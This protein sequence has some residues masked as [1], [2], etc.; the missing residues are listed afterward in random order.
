MIF[1]TDDGAEP[2]RQSRLPIDEAKK[3]HNKINRIEAERR[4][5]DMLECSGFFPRWSASMNIRTISGGMK[6]RFRH[7]HGAGLQSGRCFLPTSH[8]ALM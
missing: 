2:Y 8:N 1:Q 5:C 7:C 3:L 4:A 6:L